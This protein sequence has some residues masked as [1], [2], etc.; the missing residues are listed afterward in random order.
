MHS[1][2]CGDSLFTVTQSPLQFRNA[3]LRNRNVIL[4]CSLT[5]VVAHLIAEQMRRDIYDGEVCA[6]CLSIVQQSEPPA[7]LQE[8]RLISIFQREKESLTRFLLES[9]SNLS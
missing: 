7:A 1:K 8:A 4:P 6:S 2:D 5:F 9:R 3:I